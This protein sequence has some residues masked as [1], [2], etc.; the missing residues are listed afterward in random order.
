MMLGIVG[1]ATVAG[2]T[3]LGFHNGLMSQHATA[4]CKAAERSASGSAG[5][6]GWVAAL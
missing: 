3:V 4:V 6:R 5:G 1:T 2:T